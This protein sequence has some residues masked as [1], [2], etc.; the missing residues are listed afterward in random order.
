MRGRHAN[1]VLEA[2]V[3]DVEYKNKREKIMYQG[4]TGGRNETKLNNSHV[5]CG[6]LGTYTSA[7]AEGRV[8]WS[9]GEN[10]YCGLHVPNTALGDEWVD[11]EMP[12][13]LPRAVL[14]LWCLC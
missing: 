1:D 7:A 13:P 11:G 2:Q 10:Y 5:W 6:S 14:L 4:C 8:T 12:F 9:S 3:K